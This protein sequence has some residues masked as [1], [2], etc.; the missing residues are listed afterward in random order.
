MQNLAFNLSYEATE[1]VA[2]KLSAR[3]RAMFIWEMA[4]LRNELVAPVLAC[5]RTRDALAV[6]RA[7]RGLVANALQFI[8]QVF[9]ETPDISALLAEM[10]AEVAETQKQFADKAKVLWGPAAGR[11]AE[12]ANLWTQLAIEHWQR[13]A[14]EPPS[15]RAPIFERIMLRAVPINSLWLVLLNAG[16]PS[17]PVPRRRICAALLNHLAAEIQAQYGDG[18]LLFGP[19]LPPAPAA[20]VAHCEG[21][22]QSLAQDVPGLSTAAALR[23]YRLEQLKME[24]ERHARW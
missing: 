5:T 4:R 22:A 23:E 20:L 18:Q 21:V 3:H 13:N 8:L 9:T 6:M 7:Q 15:D 11:A 17:L 1:K 10:L 16:D 2:T 24:E 19:V 14:F 12:Q